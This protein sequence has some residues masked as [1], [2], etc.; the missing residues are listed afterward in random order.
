MTL[1]VGTHAIPES[2]KRSVEALDCDLL[3]FWANLCESLGGQ[4]NK[5][6]VFNVRP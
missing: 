3:R 4:F 6:F 2:V 5:F 1:N